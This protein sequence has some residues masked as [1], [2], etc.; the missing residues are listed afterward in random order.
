MTQTYDNNRVIS[1][2]GIEDVDRAFF[3][4]FNSK[5]NLHLLDKT[6]AKRKVPIIMVSPERWHFAR[7]EGVRDN[8]GTIILP[9]VAISRMAPSIVYD[10]DMR[11]VFADTKDDHVYAIE[12]DPKSSLIKN[13]NEARPLNID[14]SRPVY[15]IYSLPTPDHYKITYEVRIWT[16]YISEMNEVL[17]KIGNELDYKSVKSFTFSTSDGYY[18]VAFM[19]EDASDESN[20]T[21]FS[22][23]ER[24]IKTGYT[25]DV[26]AN[27]FPNVN[28][29]KSQFRRYFSQ[30][31]LVIT[32]EQV[33]TEEELKKL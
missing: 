6:G 25:F 32:T 10:G 11:P 13:L 14:P 21:D 28:D 12:I 26:S 8:N 19:A 9:V 22:D 2:I 7:E 1:N 15:Q 23:Q 24:I 16:S 4:W 20:I 31:K 27:I 3:E 17:E 29:R 18:F 30:T 33:L 5:L